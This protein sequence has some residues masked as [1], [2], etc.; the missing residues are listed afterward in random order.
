MKFLFYWSHR[1]GTNSHQVPL[2]L[3]LCHFNF[4][5]RASS[6]KHFDIAR[7]ENLRGE[8]SKIVQSCSLMA[9]L[10]IQATRSH[11]TVIL[12]LRTF[13]LDP[14]KRYWE[15]SGSLTMIFKEATRTWLRKQPRIFYKADI[16]TLSQKWNIMIEK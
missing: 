8:W 6:L 14:W 13:Y 11:C 5:K 3:C 7:S 2:T 12:H 9:S 16:N 15:D 4:D 1:W 10:V